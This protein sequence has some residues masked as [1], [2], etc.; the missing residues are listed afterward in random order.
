MSVCRPSYRDKETGKLKESEIWWYNFTF[1][2][3]CI[4]ES[5][6]SPRKTVAQDAE[7]KRR[8]ELERAFNDVT[9]RRQDRIKMISEVATKFLDDYKLRNPKSGTF[10]EYAIGHL[11][12]LIGS[13]MVVDLAAT[14]VKDYQTARSKKRPLPNRST[15]RSAFCFECSKTRAMQS[16]FG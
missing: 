2:G 9:D 4:Q 11:K 10:A 7:K 12:R 5:S 15:K 13:M 16:G 8:R 1:A 3:R 14:A 6:K